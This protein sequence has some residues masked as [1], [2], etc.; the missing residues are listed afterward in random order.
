[1]GQCEWVRR[2]REGEQDPTVNPTVKLLDF[3]TEKYDSGAPGRSGLVFETSV[4]EARS[5]TIAGG[6]DVVSTGLLAR[7]VESWRKDW[8]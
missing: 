8:E 3:F 4:T 2:L 7:C 5:K 6:Y 1:M